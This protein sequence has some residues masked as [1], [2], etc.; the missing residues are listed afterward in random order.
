MSE[1]ITLDAEPA[2]EPDT[3]LITTNLRLAPAAREEYPDALRG[4]EGSPLAQAIFAI[5]GILALTIDTDT[6]HVR[7]RPDLEMFTLVDEIHAA[8]AD[9]FLWPTTYPATVRNTR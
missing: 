3:L 5:D 1:Y 4:E 7:H 8:L 6:L 2:G 9:F